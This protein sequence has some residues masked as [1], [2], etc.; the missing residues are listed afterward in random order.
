MDTE[1]S[2]LYD[3]VVYLKDFGDEMFDKTGVNFKVHGVNK[4]FEH[5]RLFVGWRR[6]LV[7]LFKEAMHN[8]LKHAKCKNVT[9]DCSVVINTLRMESNDDGIGIQNKNNNHGLGLSNMKNRAEKLGG[10]LDIVSKKHVGTKIIF[11]GE[12]PQMSD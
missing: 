11:I 3:T 7:L 9:F 5:I 1:K 8:A 12:M 6:Q 10:R 2:S 4:D